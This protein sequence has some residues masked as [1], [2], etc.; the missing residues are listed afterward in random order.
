[1]YMPPSANGTDG[2][3]KERPYNCSYAAAAENCISVHHSSVVLLLRMRVMAF[4]TIS[5]ISIFEKSS[6]NFEILDTIRIAIF[7]ASDLNLAT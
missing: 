3:R 4:E 5:N 7:E 2:G 6:I 1:M